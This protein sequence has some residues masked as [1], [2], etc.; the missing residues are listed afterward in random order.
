MTEI[1]L[2]SNDDDDT[3]RGLRALYAAP[4]GDAYW[5]ELQSRIMARSTVGS[6]PRSLPRP[7]C[8]SRPVRPCCTP[9]RPR[10]ILPSTQC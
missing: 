3:V 10:R 4:T 2:L 8:C 6:A 7:C 1:R 9:V 5:N